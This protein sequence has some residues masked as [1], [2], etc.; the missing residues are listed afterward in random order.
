[1]K[2]L[3]QLPGLLLLAWILACAAAFAE[4]APGYSI[5]ISNPADGY[6]YA[7]YQVFAGTFS[8]EKETGKPILSDLEWGSGITEEGRAELEARY[9][10]SSAAD[11]ARA[12][13]DGSLDAVEFA[14]AASEYA[15]Q[16][17]GSADR[18]TDGCYVIPDLEG[19]YYLVK[20]LGVPEKEGAYTAYILEVAGEV[21]VV[22]KADWPVSDKKVEEISDSTGE[23]P[24]WGNTA[25]HAVG[26]AVRFTLSASV[27]GNVADYENYQ[28]VFHDTLSDGLTFDAE[29]IRVCVSAPGQESIPVDSGCY[30]LSYAE[31]GDGSVAEHGD[32]CTFELHLFDLNDLA[33]AE[34]SKVPVHANSEITVSYS[35]VLNENAVIGNPGNPNT[36]FIEYSDNP[37]NSEERSRTPA[38]E[39]AVF[40]YELLLRKTDEEKKAL[41]GAAFDL[42]Q[43]VKAKGDW[44]KK[45]DLLRV[46]ADGTKFTFRGIDSGWYRLTERKAPEG[47]N[48]MEDLYFTVGARLGEDAGS[49][50]G[51]STNLSV[52]LTDEKGVPLEGAE[53]SFQIGEEQ[54]ILSSDICNR[55]GSILPGTG[56][57]GTTCFYLAGVLLLAA[58][59]ALF[60]RKRQRSRVEKDE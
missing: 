43:Y 34:G 54:G 52:T 9:A 39:V 47:Y 28:L 38:H 41:P 57:R 2:R 42:Y 48:R 31:G 49:T 5:R 25:D 3:R 40:T 46:S 60:F 30:W 12:L 23:E 1:M 21:T 7:A 16:A 36:M 4:G 55:K 59:T 32:G 33:T 44:E 29:S 6:S 11:L 24:A 17:A 15:E 26:D 18:C 51:Y 20:N 53:Q 50:T 10:R 35:A 13:A 27:P 14:T 37:Y 19:G 8:E 56:G 58:A 22:P 45:E